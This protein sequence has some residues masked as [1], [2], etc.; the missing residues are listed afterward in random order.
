MEFR[1]LDYFSVLARHGNVGRAA[2][3]LGL[4]PPALSVSLKRL[5]T[6]MKTRLFERTPKG[7]VLTVTG[8]ALLAQIQ[9]LR[10]ARED[11]LREVSDLSQGRSGH[12]R[13]GAGP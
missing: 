9:R 1:D 7:V 10:L 11:V 2:E 3:E 13:L 5:E 6:T 8:S 4:S 12:L